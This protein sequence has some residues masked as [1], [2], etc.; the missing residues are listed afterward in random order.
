MHLEAVEVTDDEEG[1]VLQVLAVLLYLPIGGFKVLVFALVLPGEVATH[2][3]VGPA[4]RA[5]RLTRALLKGVVGAVGV[6]SRR[7][8]LSEDGAEVEEV[9]L[10]GAALG[11]RAALPARDECGHIEA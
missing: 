6:A 7:R 4:A 1:R 5:A 11:E 10:C 8:G 2:P 9:L 3:D